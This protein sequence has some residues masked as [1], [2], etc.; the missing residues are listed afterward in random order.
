MHRQ[1]NGT[2]ERPTATHTRHTTWP[3]RSASPYPPEPTFES[4]PGPRSHC[5]RAALAHTLRGQRQDG[6]LTASTRTTA[7]VAAAAVPLALMPSVATAARHSLRV[8]SVRKSAGPVAA[9]AVARVC[10]HISLT[11]TCRAIRR[12]YLLLP[13]SLAVLVGPPSP[14]AR[15]GPVY[16]TGRANVPSST[17]PHGHI[18]RRR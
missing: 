6:G 15:P 1:H 9:C 18:A 4:V 17:P 7:P 2:R 5:A 14:V 3:D 10:S 8:A 16:Q 13:V 11:R 12:P